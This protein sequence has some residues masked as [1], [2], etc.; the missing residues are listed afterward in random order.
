MTS[1]EQKNDY[2]VPPLWIDW[3]FSSLFAAETILITFSG[4]YLWMTSTSL[5]YGG[6]SIIGVGIVCF[7]IPLLLS[8][9]FHQSRLF[10]VLRKG[11][12][13]YDFKIRKLSAY[14][15]GINIIVHVAFITAE[16]M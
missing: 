12:S 15:F 11:G 7:Y 6:V 13:P 16:R 4:L 14:V 5:G 1:S 9:L 2:E 3:A 10:Y 8:F